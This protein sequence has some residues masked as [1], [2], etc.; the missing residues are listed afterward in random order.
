[1]GGPGGAVGKGT[2]VAECQERGKMGWGRFGLLGCW[3]VEADPADPLPG[4]L[5]E[6]CINAIIDPDDY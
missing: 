6:L 3:L 4:C 2:G 5:D 1:M